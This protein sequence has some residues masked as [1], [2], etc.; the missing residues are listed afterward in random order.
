M[1]LTHINSLRSLQADNPHK[2]TIA[3]SRVPLIWWATFL[4]MVCSL[5][6]HQVGAVAMWHDVSS[7]DVK[8]NVTAASLW[9]EDVQVAASGDWLILQGAPPPTNEEPQ[10][11]HYAPLF[12]LH[13]QYD[14]TGFFPTKTLR[15]SI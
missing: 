6:A 5:F 12:G 2:R 11:S 13:W 10:L 3:L 1:Q 14:D 15:L 7:V 9:S 8:G 4:V